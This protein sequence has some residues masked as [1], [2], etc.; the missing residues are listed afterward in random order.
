[1]Y[2]TPRNQVTDVWVNGKQ[3]LKNR[4]LMTI[5]EKELLE[6]AQVWRKKIKN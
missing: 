1:V 2:T 5:D 4:K 6:K 3:L